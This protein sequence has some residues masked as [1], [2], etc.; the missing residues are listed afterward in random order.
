[1]TALDTRYPI[2]GRAAKVQACIRISNIGLRISALL[3]VAMLAL[4][5]LPQAAS[6]W[7]GVE[8]ALGR[9]GEEKDGVYRVAFPRSDLRVRAGGVNI[10][11]ALA[12]T[13]WAAFQRAGSTTIVMGDL[14]VTPAELAPAVSRLSEGGFEI[15]AVHNHLAGEQPRVMYV[16][17]HGH[18]DAAELATTLRAA[19]ALTGTPLGTPRPPRVRKD[20]PMDVN[21][22]PRDPLLQQLERL[23]RFEKILGHAGAVGPGDVFQFN[24]RRAERITGGGAA[25]G[26]RMGLGTAINFQME[27]SGAAATG[28]FVLVAAEV[29]PV[30]RALRRHGIEVTALH[31]HMLDEEPR[32][33]FLHFWGRGDAEQIARGLRA[34]LDL[35][36]HAKA[37]P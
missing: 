11:P 18:G 23:G 4:A 37:S 1:M 24:I 7:Q 3:A 13:S 19:L 15:T 20:A 16:H 8:K 27:G 14:V 29:Q 5:A 26:P 6:E 12:L 17:F 32:L 2:F 22:D 9:S 31:N 10:R 28:D 33:F 35:T 34:A 36:N 21:P 25:L 30:I